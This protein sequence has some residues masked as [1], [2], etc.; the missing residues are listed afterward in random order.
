MP[1]EELLQRLCARFFDTHD[2]VERDM[3]DKLLRHYER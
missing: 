1:D 3:L 2:I